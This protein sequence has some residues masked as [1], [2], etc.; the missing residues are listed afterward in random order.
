VEELHSRAKAKEAAGVGKQ[1]RAPWSGIATSPA[2][3]AAKGRAQRVMPRHGA[4]RKVGS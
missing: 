2:Q 3:A 4:A 1:I